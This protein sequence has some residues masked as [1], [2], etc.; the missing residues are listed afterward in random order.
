MN[1]NNISAVPPRSFSTKL[2]PKEIN[3]ID[4]SLYSDDKNNIYN[5][6]KE[7]SKPSKHKKV[8][9]DFNNYIT[10]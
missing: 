8:K 2:S 7:K 4:L 9:I 5:K 3:D 10:S 1:I 6:V